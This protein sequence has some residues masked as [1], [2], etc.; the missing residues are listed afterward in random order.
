MKLALNGTDALIGVFTY[1]YLEG[2]IR[3]IFKGDII[4]TI[5][6]Y[7]IVGM[8]VS[9]CVMLYN[10]DFSFKRFMRVTIAWL[11]AVWFVKTNN[12]VNE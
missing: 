8:L 11:P 1:I 10:R 2:V 5:I 12:W 7:I 9:I 4:L 3:R 6:T